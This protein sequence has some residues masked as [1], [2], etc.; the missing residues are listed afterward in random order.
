MNGV[1]NIPSGD[2]LNLALGSTVSTF[3]S[4]VLGTFSGPEHS[5]RESLLVMATL[6]GYFVHMRKKTSNQTHI[7]LYLVLV[8]T[9][10]A[11]LITYKIG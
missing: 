6:I 9:Y 3:S 11:Y 7:F 2:D 4:F 1:N 10:P 5:I 8:L